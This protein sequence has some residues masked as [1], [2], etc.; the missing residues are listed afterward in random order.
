MPTVAVNCWV[1][2]RITLGVPG[3]TVAETAGIVIVAEADLVV[4]ACA[5]AFTVTDDGVLKLAG[6][7]YKP[8]VEI[9]PGPAVVQVT[10]VFVVPVTVAVNC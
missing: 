4:S 10:A 8:E 9:V 2:P 6:A 5:V 3:E 7:V 1:A